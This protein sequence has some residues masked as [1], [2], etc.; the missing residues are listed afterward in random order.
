MTL[1]FSKIGMQLPGISSLLSSDDIDSDGI[2]KHEFILS[3]Q[4]IILQH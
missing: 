4:I 1:Y 2:A 3:Y